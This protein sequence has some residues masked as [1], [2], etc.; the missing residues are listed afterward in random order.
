M[1]SMLKNFPF[2]KTIITVNN[3]FVES[4]VNNSVNRQQNCLTITEERIKK[5]R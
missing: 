3:S 5:S 4:N 2:M 1:A